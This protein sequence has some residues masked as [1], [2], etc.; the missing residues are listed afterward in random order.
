MYPHNGKTT[1]RLIEEE[2]EITNSPCKR[3]H[4][5]LVS[6]GEQITIAKLCMCLQKMGYDAISYTGW[7]IPILTNHIYGNARVKEIA[8]DRIRKDLS[9]RKIVVVAGFQ[10]IDEDLNITTLGRGGSDTTAVAL[11]A[12]LNAE[13]CDIYTDVDGIFSADPRIVKHVSKIETISYD[14][15]LEL[16]SLGAK[17]LHNRCVEIGKKYNIPIY[18]KSTFEETSRGT[19]VTSGECIENLCISGVAKE[20]HIARITLRWKTNKLGRIDKVFRLLADYNINV[21][22]IVQAFGEHIA[23]DISF[24]VKE[25]DLEKAL[26]ILQE[27]ASKFDI[28]EI[29]SSIGMSKVS[30][31][32]IGIANNP[33]VAATLFEVLYEN[34]I[35]V[36]MISTSEIKISVLVNSNVAERALNAIHN[37]F[38]KET[39]SV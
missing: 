30:I 26:E 12:A 22:I 39:V 38:I 14:E 32:G 28:Q 15:M 13:K 20:D 10:G 16:A 7:Q 21:D 27:H 2:A 18:V 24:T 6:T 37:K 36:H 1:D 19:L 33:G 23:K 31:V 17:V 4:D 34:N 3:E 25:N 29:T 8:T 35:N 5:V 9:Q 11:A